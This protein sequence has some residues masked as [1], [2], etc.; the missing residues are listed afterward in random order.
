MNEQEHIMKI[1][2]YHIVESAGRHIQLRGQQ[3]LQRGDIW[4]EIWMTR[5]ISLCDQGSGYYRKRKEPVQ[6]L[7]VWKS[8]VFLWSSKKAN[9][10][11]AEEAEGAERRDVGR[12]GREVGRGNIIQSLIDHGQEFAFIQFLWREFWPRWMALSDLYVT[13]SFHC[14][15]SMVHGL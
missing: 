1:K 7:Q 6:S 9:E 15:D 5:K 8:V 13:S 12:W 2:Q 4:L 11:E 10:A 3:T 14:M